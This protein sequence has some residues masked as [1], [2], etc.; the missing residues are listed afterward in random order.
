LRKCYTE[1]KEETFSG[2]KTEEFVSKYFKH[3][4]EEEE[5]E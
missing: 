4:D 5:A 3:F 2:L 1:K